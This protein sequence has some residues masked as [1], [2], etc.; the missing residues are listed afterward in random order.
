MSLAVNVQSPNHWTAREFPQMFISHSSG[1]WKPAI[2]APAWL[3][4]WWRPASLI[5]HKKRE[6]E[7]DAERELHLYKGINPIMRVSPS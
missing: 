7:R 6:R 5:I 1:S 4:S 3:G 2:R